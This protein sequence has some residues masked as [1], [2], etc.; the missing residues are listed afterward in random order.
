[1]FQ[2]LYIIKYNEIL[3]ERFKSQLS[4]DKRLRRELL[5]SQASDSQQQ[6][7]RC[8]IS[9]SIVEPKSKIQSNNKDDIISCY[10]R[11][12]EHVVDDQAQMKNCFENRTVYLT[13]EKPEA[14]KRTN[15]FSEENDGSYLTP[16]VHKQQFNGYVNEN[17]ADL[18]SNELLLAQRS[19]KNYST[20]TTAS[21]NSHSNRLDS[22]T[23]LSDVFFPANKIRESGSNVS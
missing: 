7:T 17:R 19:Q 22:I 10:L 1:M 20:T 5:S 8:N 9:S 16:V 2:I 12:I 4:K 15:R 21:K 11:P 6:Q 13:V 3:E 23:T 18:R 14:I